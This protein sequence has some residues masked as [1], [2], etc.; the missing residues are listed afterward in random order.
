MFIKH[1]TAIPS[2]VA[3]DNS[4][5]REI[6]NPKK[7]DISIHY[8]LAWAYVKPGEKTLVHELKVSEVYFILKGK[9]TMH[10]NNEKKNIGKDDTIYI[11][12]NAAQFIEN[13]GEENLEF[14]CIVDPVWTPET[15]TILKE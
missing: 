10:I 4:L 9:G 2:I 14:L 8:S 5:L 7:E 3:G 13:T 15:E 1:L 6:L 11:L 12:P